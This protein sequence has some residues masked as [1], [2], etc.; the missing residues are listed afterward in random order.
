MTLDELIEEL[1][2]LRARCPAAGL[3]VVFPRFSDPPT[4]DRGCVYIGDTQDSEGLED[5]SNA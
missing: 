5:D 4:Y 2:A 1:T 3:A